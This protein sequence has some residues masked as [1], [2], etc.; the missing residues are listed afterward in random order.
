MMCCSCRGSPEATVE[1]EI[2]VVGAGPAGIV[3]ALELADAGVQVA[4]IESGEESFDA[5]VQR[6]G[7]TVGQ[8]P[9]HAPMSL[10]TRRQ[11]GGASNVWAGRCVPFDPID[12]RPRRIT[13]GARWPIGYEELR[14]YFPRACDWFVCGEPH[15]DA[16]EIPRLANSSLIPGWPGGEIDATALER[17]SLPT[18]FGT[19]Y[20]ARLRSSPRL[21]LITGLTCTEIV[22]APGGRSVDHLH[23]RRLR[24]PCTAVRASR[25]VLA[26]GG[27]ETTRLLFASDRMRRGG[28]GNHSGHLGRWYMG[29]VETRVANVHFT[30]PPAATIYGYERDTDGVYVRRRFTFSADYIAA[31]DLPNAALWLVNPQLG[32]PSHRSGTLSFLYL[33]LSSPFGSRLVSEAIRLRQ[34]ETAHPI[35][36]RAHLAN[37]ARD[38]AP[39]ARFAIVVGYQR[40]LERAHKLPGVFVPS[41]SNVYPLL[42]HGEHLPHHSSHVSPTTERDALGMARLR[43]CMHF[44]DSDVQGAVQVHKHF[45]RYLRR[46]QLG[47]LQPLYDDPATAIRKQVYGGYHQAGKTRMSARAE[48]GVLDRDLAVH[49]FRDLFVASSSAFVT[50]SQANTTFMIVVFAL[51]LAD[52]LLH[53]R[54]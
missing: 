43:T 50:S 24:G 32:D 8:D 30:T 51:R 14:R 41:A 20:R 52:H 4:L 27:L 3:L 15:F 5:A 19:F 31:H 48:D 2:A 26:C 34:I 17:W 45:D 38:L 40:Y 18:N 42:Y 46:H 28:I 22:C 33:V 54:R 10:A 49:G 35:S 25:Y 11:L 36:K 12:F 37:V 53:T 13:A 21:R 7:D 23:A 39:T 1:T 6:L 9:P 16:R 47:H 44:D 29:H